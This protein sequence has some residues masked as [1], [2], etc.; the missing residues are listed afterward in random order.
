M[1]RRCTEE[2][3]RGCRARDDDAGALGRVSA[4]G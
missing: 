3:I 2:A 4:L 1:A